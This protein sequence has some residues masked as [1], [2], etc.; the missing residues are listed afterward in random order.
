MTD[1]EADLELERALVLTRRVTKHSRER[2]LERSDNSREGTMC[3]QEANFTYSYPQLLQRAYKMKASGNL[4]DIPREIQ[5]T[6]MEEPKVECMSP[7][8]AVLLNFKT[9]CQIMHRA[10]EPV[11]MFLASE[12]DVQTSLA[13]E[14]SSELILSCTAGSPSIVSVSSVV[15]AVEMY[16]DNYVLCRCCGSPSTQIHLQKGCN[17][18]NKILCCNM[19]GERR[20]IPS[21]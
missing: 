13:A 17:E 8:M 5:I 12:L 7:V 21:W 16:I 19:C 15:H 3:K 1:V 10:P 4:D 6:I 18:Q 2:R 11:Q 20:A 14:H 9:M